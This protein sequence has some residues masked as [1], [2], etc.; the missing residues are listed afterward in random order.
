MLQTASTRYRPRYLGVNILGACM[1]LG[2]W[3]L[4]SFEWCWFVDEE[5]PAKALE[6]DVIAKEPLCASDI[7]ITPEGGVEA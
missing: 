6:D 2:L 5:L 7:A 4:F 3:F 1:S